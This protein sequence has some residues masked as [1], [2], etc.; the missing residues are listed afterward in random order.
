M[1][2]LMIGASA[3]RLGDRSIVLAGGF[4][5]MTKAPHYSYLRKP[6]PYGHSNILDSIVFDGLTD[7][8]S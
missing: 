5:S 2:S 1:K 7:V 8:Y 4:E 3:I 6:V